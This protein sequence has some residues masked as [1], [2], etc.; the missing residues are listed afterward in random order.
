ME[1]R[2]RG[3]KALGKIMSKSDKERN[4]VSR[5]EVET[6]EQE[7]Y[8]IGCNTDYEDYDIGYSDGSDYDDEPGW[9]S[10]DEYGGYNGYDDYTI[11]SAFDGDP[12]ATWN[13][14]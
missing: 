7:R 14:D 4:E 8:N 1:Y 10:Y 5:I 13:I 6:S 2:T 3:V 12:E 9:G 11:D